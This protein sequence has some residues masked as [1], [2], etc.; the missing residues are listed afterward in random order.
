MLNALAIPEGSA[1]AYML[2][3][4]DFEAMA[5]SYGRVGG[6]DRVAT[7]VKA[8]VAERGSERVLVLDGGDALQGSYTAL[9]SRGADMLAVLRAIGVAATTGHWEFTLGAGRVLELFGDLDRRSSEVAFLAGNVRDSDFNDPV[10]P[11]TRLFERGGVCVG[12]IGQAY[13]YTPIANPR[14]LIPRW[15]FGIRERDVRASVAAARA[16]GAEVVVL[17][18]HNGFDVDAELASRVEGID[19]ILTAHTHDALPEPVRIGGTRLIAS[20]SHGKFLSRLDIE[21]AGGRVKD[22]AYRLIPVLADAITP[23]PE[24]A[25][26]IA[27]IRAPH[28]AMLAS[29]RDVRRHAR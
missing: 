14:W 27:E 10:F 28:A 2:S 11:S 23:D 19:I 16:R 7:L 4:Q 9:L 6:M 17:L 8:I 12:V 1:A 25:K 20:G 26:L 15:S 13:P 29:E 24:V 21:I 22:V 3:C 5:K 18:S